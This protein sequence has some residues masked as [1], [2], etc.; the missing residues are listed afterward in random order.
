MA[1][2]RY[3]N[4]GSNSGVI[5]YEIGED[6]IKVEF[7]DHSLYLYTHDVTGAGNVEHMKELA[8]SGKG[9]STFISQKVKNRYASR[10]R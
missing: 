8:L 7:E 9:L 4:L 1:L 6:N 3:K 2:H 10:L 5:A